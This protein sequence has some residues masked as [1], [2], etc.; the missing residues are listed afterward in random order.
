MTLLN[1][2]LLGT[3]CQPTAPGRVEQR[4]NTRCPPGET[5][6]RRPREGGRPRKLAGAERGGQV[7]EEA[8]LA[9]GRPQGPPHPPHAAGGPAAPPRRQ[10]QP[11]PALPHCKPTLKARRGTSGDRYGASGSFHRTSG[12]RLGAGQPPSGGQRERPADSHDSPPRPAARGRGLAPLAN[13]KERW[14][15]AEGARQ[16]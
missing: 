10:P 13:G 14:A 7:L 1:L 15:G 2:S 16:R 4:T 12:T 6:A 11:Q 3:F 8:Q 5:P 9:H